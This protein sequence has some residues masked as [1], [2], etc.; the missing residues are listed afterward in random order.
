M[1]IYVVKH[2]YDNGESYEDYREYEDTWL[3]S[4]YQKAAN[5]FW[6]S[7]VGDY[8]GKYTLIEWELDTQKRTKL[9][10]SAWVPC[11][12]WYDEQS[13]EYFSDPENFEYDPW[14]QYADSAEDWKAVYACAE[15]E[16]I[17]DELVAE[18]EWLVHENENYEL[19]K[20]LDRDNIEDLCSTLKVDSNPVTGGYCARF[21]FRDRAYYVDLSKMGYIGNECMVFDDSG[22]AIW[23]KRSIP[24]S[25]DSLKECVKEYLLSTL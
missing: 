2:F 21:I 23:Y 3:Y 4:T 25:E 20:E 14:K 12:S 13:D 18:E 1:K 9:E 24:L 7:V 22:E 17:Q 6:A 16:S 10:E 5:F 8:E 15:S 19:F 11:T